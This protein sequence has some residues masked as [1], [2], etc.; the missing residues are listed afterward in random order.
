MRRLFAR[1]ASY[2]E[3]EKILAD[4]C[5]VFTFAGHYICVEPK[6]GPRAEDGSAIGKGLAV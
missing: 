6:E 4:P 1:H 3:R 2:R 5:P